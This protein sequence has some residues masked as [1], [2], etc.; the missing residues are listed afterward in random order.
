MPFGSLPLAVRRHP[1]FR[2]F[3]SLQLALLLLAV[4]IVASIVGT[5]YE[6]RLTAE[7]ARAYIYEAWWFNLWL[8]LLVL[9]LATVAFSRMPWRQ[10]HTGFLLTHLGI[11]ILLFGA[12]IGKIFGIEG[13]I[14]LFENRDPVSTLLI[15][16]KQLRISVGDGA[17]ER[18]PVGIIHRLPTPEK[19]R[20]LGSHAGWKLQAIGATD[21]LLPVFTARSVSEG[22][23]PAVKVRLKTAM[24]NQTLEE[25]LWTGEE[26]EK[27]FDLGLARIRLFEGEAPPVSAGK[28]KPADETVE[29][30]ENLFVFAKMPD[31]QVGKVVQG[32]SAGLKARLRE[33]MGRLIIELS[34]DGKSWSLTTPVG[35][36]PRAWPLKGTALEVRAVSYWPDFQLRDNK[37]QT[38]SNEPNN[39]AILLEIRGRTVPV[40]AEGVHGGGADDTSPNRLDLYVGPR[41]MSYILSSRKNGES[42]GTLTPGSPLATGWA[43]WSFTVEEWLPRAEGDTLFRPRGESEAGLP[44]QAAPVPGV[45]VRL[46]KGEERIEEWIP[47][48]WV[49]QTPS[50]EGLL[51]ISYGW[52][53]EPLPFGLK[54]E[55]FQLERYGGTGN[56][57]EFRSKLR[58]LAA[59]GSE[60]TG[61]CSMNQPMNFP[62]DWWRGWTG[63]TWKMSQASWNP[64]NLE[65]SSIQ[66]LRDPGWLFKWVG[67]LI[68]CTGIFCLFYLRPVKAD[69][70]PPGAEGNL[71]R[72]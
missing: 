35:E 71:N 46:T 19:P 54:L 23:H 55:D 41:G 32:G 2:F 49:I 64:E 15:N 42:R 9:N 30:V 10:S 59:D 3:S 1:V 8:L 34:R 27:V 68:L 38:I 36:V 72:R 16:E 45:Q 24:M 29:V 51:R 57:S 33:E 53:T 5:I 67:S 26:E 52:R 12:F 21:T 20:S 70:R 37:P 11:I 61:S 17:V 31:Q 6:S 39:P 50:K 44:G 65:Q 25:W 4:L 18:L 63:L 22:G 13:S 66:I 69:L 28:K 48:G 56:P 58:V 14:T 43:D 40:Q 62:D 47:Q 7:V 60:A